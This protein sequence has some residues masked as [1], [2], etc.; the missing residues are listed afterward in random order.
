MDSKGDTSIL[1]QM[2]HFSHLN[3][4]IQVVQEYRGNEPLHHFLKK[5]FARH[6]KFGS[7][8]RKRISQLCYGFYRVA[9][10]FGTAAL[11][12]SR[13]QVTEI[14]LAG[15]FL[16][17]DQPDQLLEAT[18]PSWNKVNHTSLAEK[19]DILAHYNTGNFQV[20]DIFP[21]NGDLSIEIDSREFTLSH[22][23]QPDLFIRIRPGFEAPVLAKL[24]EVNIPFVLLAPNSVRLQNGMKV[25]KFFGIDRE[26]V[27]Q[28]LNSQRVGEMLEIAYL[29]C[30]EK[31]PGDNL[32]SDSLDV[33]DCCAASGGKSILASDI[34]QKMKLT[35]SD[36]RESIIV[37]LKKRFTVAGLTNYK[38]IVA[39]LSQTQVY[40]SVIKNKFDLIIADVPCTGSGTWSR[41]P[42]QLYFFQDSVID[43]YRTLQRRILRNLIPSLKP[44]GY[45]LYITC[46]VFKRENEEIVEFIQSE[47]GLQAIKMSLLKGYDKK[48]DTM[49]TALL[50]PS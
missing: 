10:A 48:A 43:E 16:T 33:W 31:K 30:Q 14:I 36:I 12:R 19:L 15:L 27:I 28:D 3:S 46:S 35:V 6:K 8:D 17:T 44:G 37:N 5:F 47:F 21:F 41:T 2:M 50:S 40:P 49:F 11:E 18:Q 13:E 34:I 1:Q 26:V 20:R 25:E 38:S 22:L 39:D 7:K 9:R 42:E 32:S 45:L 23:V 4:A 29:L 24:T